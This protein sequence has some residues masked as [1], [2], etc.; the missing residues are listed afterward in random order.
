MSGNQRRS[1]IALGICVIA[2]MFVVESA[3][4]HHH[5]PSPLSWLVWTVLGAVA[6]VAAVAAIVYRRR[7]KAEAGRR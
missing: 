1:A 7:A 6:A 2:L 5:V 4:A 3:V